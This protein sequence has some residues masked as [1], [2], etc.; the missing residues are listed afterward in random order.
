LKTTDTRATNY[1]IG[2][3]VSGSPRGIRTHLYSTSLT[4]NPYMY[5]TLNNPDT[6]EVHDVGE[7]WAEM[8][9]EVL[10][11][12]IDAAGFEKDLYNADAI[13]GNTLAMKYIV[14]GFKLQPCNPTFLSARDA[15]LQAEKAITNGKYMC[16]I[17]KA[18][19]KRGLGTRAAKILGFRFNSSSIPSEC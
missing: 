11:N 8:L 6:S 9:Y 4:E 3:Y 10:W 16:P 7:V 12:L 17:W 2:T 19:A 18:F 1:A 14:N 5:N 15:I 13:A